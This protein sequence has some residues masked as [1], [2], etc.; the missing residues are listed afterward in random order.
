MQ[1]QRSTNNANSKL[2]GS[3]DEVIAR[4]PGDSF[5]TEVFA[6]G[7]SLLADEPVADGGNNTGPSP[8]DLLAAALATCTS[9][10]LKM[11]ASRKAIAL[12]SVTVSVRHGKIHAKD[13]SD[14]ESQTGRI[15]E[16][17]R[18]LTIDGDLND[19]QRQRMLEIADLCPVHKTLHGE[20]RVRTILTDSA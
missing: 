3:I 11:Y 19:E 5:T 7:H 2:A 18:E 17:R 6:A 8:Y 13:C 9:M 15:D 12:R 4:T 20:V 1:K 14:C 10:T 16:F